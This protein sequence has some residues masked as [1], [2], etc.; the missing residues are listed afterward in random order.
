MISIKYIDELDSI[1]DIEVNSYDVIYHGTQIDK[2]T[3]SI[4]GIANQ[5]NSQ[6]LQKVHYDNE[7]FKLHI[8]NYK[9]SLHELDKYFVESNHLKIL[10]ESTSLD[11]PEIIYLLTGITRSKTKPIIDI[12]YLEPDDYHREYNNGVREQEFHLSD[13]INKF[14]SLPLYSINT[15]QSDKAMLVVTLGFESSRFGQLLSE[16]DGSSFRQIEAF[17][18]VPAYK[19]GWENRC[20]Y[21]H[22][23]YLHP[24]SATLRMFPASNPFAFIQQLDELIIDGN[25]L[26]LL[27]VS[28]GTKPAAIAI[29]IFLINKK[30]Q[31]INE[32]Q[33]S[34][35]L[36]ALYDFPIKSKDRSVGIGKIY[37]YTLSIK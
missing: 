15:S 19:P 16:D 23:E 35:Q 9:I 36:G 14:Q 37:R 1:G 20:L 4:I 28:M 3:E 30:L 18:G 22:M 25:K 7:N 33:H 5:K 6:S 17:I 32:Q 27:F 2:R 11:L 21:K 29:S 10:I 34:D 31:C 8:G 24:D 26:K 13:K 12:V